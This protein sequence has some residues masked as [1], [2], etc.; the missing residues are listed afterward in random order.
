M[1]LEPGPTR[2]DE[3]KTR[4]E[5]TK[6]G[7]GH[8]ALPQ[9]GDLAGRTTMDDTPGEEAPLPPGLDALCKDPESRYAF[10]KELGRGGLG[11]VVDALDR[12][13]GRRVALKIMLPGRASSLVERFL[14]EGRAAG[15]LMHPNIVPIHEIGVL[16]HEGE[17]TP[18]FTMGK[19]V[20]RDLDEIL[21][22]IASGDPETRKRWNRHRLLRVFQ[23]VCNAMAYAHDHGVIHRDLKP[24][25]I[26]VGDYGEVFVVD[27]GL[28]K[29]HMKTDSP[30]S[31]DQP[32]QE[33]PDRSKYVDTRYKHSDITDKILE[34]YYEVYNRLRPGHKESVYENAMKI[35]LGQV[36]DEVKSQEQ[37]T[38]RY[39]EKAIGK[40]APD[41]LIDE[42]VIVEVKAAKSLISAYE[43]QLTRYLNATG[44]EVGLLLNFGSPK[45]QFRRRFVSASGEAIR[46]STDQVDQEAQLTLE[47]M[48]MGTPAYMPPEQAAGRVGEI[49]ERSDIFSLGAILYELLTLR[50]PFEGDTVQQVIFHIL[51]KEAAPAPSSRISELRERRA[52]QRKTEAA[53]LEDIP[54]EL[55]EIVLRALSKEKAKRYA[56]ARDLSEDLQLFLEGEKERARNHELAEAKVKEGKARVGEMETLRADLKKKKEEI[57]QNGKKVKTFWPTRDKEPFWALEDEADRLQREIVHAFTEA[58]NRFQEALGFEREN[59]HARAAIA[60]LYWDRF[61]REEEGGD[62]AE[63]LHCEE[64]VR[65]YDDG[66]Y[67][68]RLEGDGTLSVST[69]CFPCRCLTEGR[70]VE[71]DEMDVLGYR[72]F[73]GRAMDGT[74]YAEGLPELEP[75]EPIRLRTHGASCETTP[76]QDVDVWLFR[77]EEKHRILVPCKP[78]RPDPP[79]AAPRQPD[80]PDQNG[81]AGGRTKPSDVPVGEVLDRLYD[82]ASPYRPTEG[83]YL[84]KTPIP[85][86]RI[87]MGAYLLVLHKEGFHPV[88]RPVHIGRS[89]E[90]DVNVTLHR[91]GEIPEAFV[92]VPEGAFFF[93]G[94]TVDRFA[95]SRM[96]M[97]ADGFFLG[98]YPVTC[99]DYLAF[100]NDLASPDRPD[101]PSRQADRLDWR[102]LL[103]P[104]ERRVP[105]EA[106]GAGPYWPVTEDGRYAIPTERWLAQ[107]PKG[108]REQVRRLSQTHVDWEED[109]PVYG[110]SWEDAVAFGVWFSRKR[111]ILAGLPHD[112]LWEKAARGPDGRM[113][114]F[115]HRFDHRYANVLG[116]LEER[117]RPSPVHAF[118]E[119]EGPFGAR[120]QAGNAGEW[121]INAAFNDGRRLMRGGS[122][123]H[124]WVSAH[125]VRRWANFSVYVAPN[126]GFRL[127]VYPSASTF[128]TQRTPDP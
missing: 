51:S 98:R 95:E 62:E 87:H 110:V 27:W 66:R 52:A 29:L 76:L 1:S 116:S 9:A 4:R 54:P 112:I 84:G 5:P 11:V 104:A 96:L 43:L 42:K 89:A 40:Y 117:A 44:I 78:A 75:R 20:G 34:C 23:E 103:G 7:D 53:P 119:D 85:S 109:W 48:V 57:E 16:E 10:L 113:F 72:P 47:G 90:K 93:Q 63:L 6:I 61:L 120:G 123:M 56:T 69:R 111:N 14:L 125:A 2:D 65:Q 114:P 107:A 17:S 39:G 30:E 8:E 38:V 101:A 121:C 99:R 55:D 68:A 19:I 70:W 73:S 49:D 12:H 115:G 33:S 32:D 79:D 71:P 36:F 50:P 67:A 22:G 3:E 91:E 13:F 118:P 81:R 24:A 80:H 45:P 92:Q 21:Q 97:H 18:F 35:E 102:A 128:S 60:D 37:L 15:R 74:T 108:L 122:W 31:P 94:G 88:R 82:P 77:F 86:F 64:M 26:M 28:A 127:A 58:G 59:A 46:S 106:K 124:S 41:L 126:I 105:R 100:L 25:N 83:L